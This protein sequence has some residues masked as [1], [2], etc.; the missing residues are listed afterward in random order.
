MKIR[1]SRPDVSVSAEE[2]RLES[3]SS[4]LL[5]G[6]VE[7][8]VGEIVLRVAVRR[9][10]NGELRAFLPIF[11]DGES[12]LDGVEVPSDLRTEIVREALT[13]YE[14]AEARHA[15]RRTL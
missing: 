5:A 11:A 12:C 3:P 1:E 6:F 15:A 14:E 8:Q 10:R 13:A 2:T 4:S 9:F 7:V